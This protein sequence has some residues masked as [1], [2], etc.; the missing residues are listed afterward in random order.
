[1]KGQTV[2]EPT[3]EDVQAILDQFDRSDWDELL[4]ESDDFRLHVYKTPGKRRQI[5]AP[6]ALQAPTVAVPQTL[7]AP[8]DASTP[9]PQPETEAAAPPS[10]AAGSDA[11]HSGMVIVRAPNLGTFYRASKPGAEPFVSI[12]Q[13]VEP[14]TEVCLIE[15][16]KLFTA[17]QAGVSGTVREILVADADLVEH[18]QPLLVIEPAAS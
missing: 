5:S 16:M 17:V 13:T 10:P 2:S 14:T 3:V 7:R 9:A 6:P 8:A 11:D 12:G 4:I 15:V 18:D 1:M